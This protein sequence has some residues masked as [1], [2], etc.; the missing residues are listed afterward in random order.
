MDARTY[1]RGQRTYATASRYVRHMC[2]YVR[3]LGPHQMRSAPVRSSGDPTGGR[4]KQPPAS[5]RRTS[6]CP[7]SPP[8][9]PSPIRAASVGS[10][11]DPTGS[12]RQQEQARTYVHTLRWAAHAV[13]TFF[14]RPKSRRGQVR[15]RQPMPSRPT[16]RAN[17]DPTAGRSLPGHRPKPPSTCVRACAC[18]RVCVCVSVSVCLFV[19]VS[20]CL[21]VC[22]FVCM[23]VRTY[24][25][26]CPAIHGPTARAA[27]TRS[28]TPANARSR[29]KAAH[30]FKPPRA[31]GHRGRHPKRGSG[32]GGKPAPPELSS[33]NSMRSRVLKSSAFH[34]RTA[35]SYAARRAVAHTVLQRPPWM[36]S[37]K[38]L[39]SGVV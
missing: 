28:R 12:T 7:S 33:V 11:G 4:P 27:K 8:F 38:F 22:V 34:M 37:T 3:T 6:A 18:V 13:G 23:C 9:F 14:L 16:V 31:R 24:V 10:M 30:M 36:W 39:R 17:F 20:V 35:S 21:C 26:M 19:C 25:R 5:T 2:T 32:Q 1:V 29:G 15:K